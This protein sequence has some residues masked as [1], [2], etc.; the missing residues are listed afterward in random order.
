M[1]PGGILFIRDYGRYDMAELRLAG[2]K[3]AKIKENFYV[4]SDGT[5]AYYFE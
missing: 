3:N 2:H 1:K 5:R 4:R